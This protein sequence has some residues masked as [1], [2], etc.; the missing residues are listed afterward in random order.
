MARKKK[1]VPALKFYPYEVDSSMSC[2][3]CTGQAVK[4]SV[5]IAG[6]LVGSGVTPFLILCPECQKTLLKWFFDRQIQ[7]SV[8]NT[9]KQLSTANETAV[10]TARSQLPKGLI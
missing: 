4:D 8:E 9:A 6:N 3:G 2:S 10:D 1:E 7:Q 5:Q